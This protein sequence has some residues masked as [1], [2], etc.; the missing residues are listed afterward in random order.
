MPDSIF[1]AFPLQVPQ[2]PFKNIAV[3][4][5][6]KFD[7]FVGPICPPKNRDMKSFEDRPN[8]AIGPM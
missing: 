5:F 1:L 6:F 2:V 3:E 7:L 4:L 8:R